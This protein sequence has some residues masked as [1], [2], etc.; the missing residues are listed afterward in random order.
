MISSDNRQT[1]L[2]NRQILPEKFGEK[3]SRFF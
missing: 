2:Q 3:L 1:F